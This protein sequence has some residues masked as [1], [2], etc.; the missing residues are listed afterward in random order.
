[1]KRFSIL[2]GLL[3]AACS[4]Q[5]PAGGPT[6]EP[7][8]SAASP[9]PSPTRTPTQ[10]ARK[11]VYA[12]DNAI[13]LYDVAANTATQIAQGDAVRAPRFVT[14]TK[15]SFLQGSD[16]A[17]TLR[18]ID[19]N[20]KQVQD[21]FTAA[22]GINAY[23]WSPDRS[24]VAYVTTDDESYPQI[25]FRQMEGE[26]LTQSVSTL[27]RALGRGFSIDDQIRI[28]FSRDGAYVLVVYTP[29][30]GEEGVD[31]TLDQSQLQVRDAGGGL[32]FGHALSDDPTMGVWSFDGRQIFYRAR[33]VARTWVASS[34]DDFAIKGSVKW[35]NPSASP[36]N[37]TVFY[38]TGAIS[39]R[40]EVRAVNVRN[41]V[42]KTVSKPGYFHPVAADVRTVWAQRVTRCEPDCLEPVIAAPE[43]VAITL[44]DGK[45]RKIA[46]PTLLDI[47]V[48]YR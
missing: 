31:P 47:D 44:A 45:Q 21:L 30:D 39:E 3:L 18:L 16:Q 35:F 37:R 46:L 14:A 33:S 7:T 40:V 43:V 12:A 27:A 13:G 34:G 10:R 36:D 5:T 1:M 9:S 26:A 11:V 8:A 17:A 20:T 22:T 6:G 28:E 15:V 42:K 32:A 25:V 2:F 19:V 48:Q 29:A 4:A 38:D 24:L 41:G 23:A